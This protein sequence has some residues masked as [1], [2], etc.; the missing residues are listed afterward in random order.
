MWIVRLA[1]RRPYTFVVAALLLLLLTPFVLLRTPTDIFPAINIPV[2]SVVWQYT[3]LSARE[4][5]QRMVYA[6]ERALTTTVNN[7]QHAEPTSYAGVGV[8]KIFFQPGVSPDGAVAEVTAESQTILKQLP[9]GTT[10]PLIIQYN[11]STVPMLQYGISGTNLSEQQIFDVA[12]NTIRVGLISVPGVG[13]PYPYGGKQRVVSVDLNPKALEAQNLSPQDVVNALTTQNLVFP[14]GSAKIGANEYPIDLNTSPRLLDRLNDLPIKTLDGA[15]IRV[16]DVAQVRDGY[17]PQQNVVRQDGVRSTMLTVLKNGSAS[18]LQVASGVK[19]AMANV[20]KTV[21][22]NLQV[23]QF[24][25][26]SIFVTAAVSGVVREGAIAAALTALMILLFLGSWRSTLIIAISIPLSILAS[27]AILSA[28]GET[29]NLMTL[30]GLALA[31]GILVDDATVTIENV[32]RHLRA[33]ETLEN[34]ILIGAGEIALPAMVSTLCICIVFVPMFFLTG[35]AGYLFAP[36]AEAVVF[37]VLASYVLSRTLVPTLVMW[38]EQSKSKG[39]SSVAADV[40]RRNPGQNRVLGRLLTSAATI[41]SYAFRPLV[42]L[43]RKFEHGFDRFRQGY[44][45]LLGVILAHR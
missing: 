41:S 36:L 5:E 8:V 25:D 9:P 32:E 30:G 21:T 1:L 7:I 16:R 44:H 45:S 23:K 43:Q 11:A 27:L 37:A 40:R 18:T 28:I 29:I 3:G 24:A 26:Q 15:V 34:G 39:K 4:I 42:A 33:G 17:M 14:S 12:M 22:E 13:I 10:P 20:M 6:E 31:V 2:V 38:F 35:V 19:A